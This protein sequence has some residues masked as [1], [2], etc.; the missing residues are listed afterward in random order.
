MTSTLSGPWF[1]DLELGL[2]FSAPGVTLTDGLATLHQAA[3]G[4]RLRLCLDHHLCRQVTGQ[5][6]ALVNPMLLCNLTIGQTT[7]ASQRVLGNLFYRGLLIR[8]P[9]FLGDTL[10]TCSRVVARRQKP[11][12]AGACCLWNGRAGDRS[13]Q[14]A[15]RTD[16]AVLALPHGALSGP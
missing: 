13:A 4:D 2:D 7:W 5:D 1:E 15:R 3:F 8:K 12:Q 10:R 14:S 6:S 9:V 11:P 16:H